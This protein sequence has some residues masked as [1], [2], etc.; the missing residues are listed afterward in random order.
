MGDKIAAFC[1]PLTEVNF[2]EATCSSRKG[3][4]ISEFP[5]FRES[6]RCID[7]RSPEEYMSFRPLSFRSVE[8]RPGA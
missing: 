6:G 1:A 4:G 7:V 8:P 2:N 5:E 3:V